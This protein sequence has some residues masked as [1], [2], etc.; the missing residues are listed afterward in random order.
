MYNAPIA[1][2]APGNAAQKSSDWSDIA[3]WRDRGE[4]SLMGSMACKTRTMTATDAFVARE[5]IARMRSQLEVTADAA[6]RATL[7]RLLD[8]QLGRL[9]VAEA[10]ERSELD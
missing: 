7:R 4:R 2:A 3:H 1:D 10:C 8:E 6:T 9:R 5:N